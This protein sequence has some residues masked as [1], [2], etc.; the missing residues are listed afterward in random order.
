MG[1]A[2]KGERTVVAEVNRKSG[3]EGN[4]GDGR[5][6]GWPTGAEEVEG[7]E[8]WERGGEARERRCV[9]QQLVKAAG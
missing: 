1:E 4:G 9:R 8:K 6:T 3:R 5:E 7:S 2:G